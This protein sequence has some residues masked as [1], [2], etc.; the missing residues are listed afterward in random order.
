M[1]KVVPAM[2]FDDL[3]R[4]EEP[5]SQAR[6]LVLGDGPL[7]ALEDPLPRLVRDARTAVPE[8]ARDSFRERLEGDGEEVPGPYLTALI[9]RFPMTCSIR[10]RSTRT[11][12][13]SA[14][15]I[16]RS[17]PFLITCGAKRSTTPRTTSAR[18]SGARFSF[19]RP[20]WIRVMSSM[21]STSR[22]KRSVWYFT[23]PTKTR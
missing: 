2:G 14:R 10:W 15:V 16:R 23:F 19:I 17:P 6:S 8:E 9:R 12:A 21:S 11:R 13:E 22:D 18:S 3:P 4:D 20:S 7:E 1:R 5:E